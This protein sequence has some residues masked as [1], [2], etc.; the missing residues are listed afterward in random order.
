MNPPPIVQFNVL[1]LLLE[2]AQKRVKSGHRSLSQPTDHS[3]DS[4]RLQID[5]TNHTGISVDDKGSTP[6]VQCQT[7]Q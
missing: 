3:L 4:T 5:P 2:E 6:I 1:F 7:C